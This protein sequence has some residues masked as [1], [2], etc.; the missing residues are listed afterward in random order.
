[1]FRRLFLDHPASVGESYLEHMGVASRFGFRMIGG[2]MGCAIH[3]V[4]PFLFKTRGSD[5][6]QALN[7]ELVAKRNAARAA[8]TQM[9]TVEYII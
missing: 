7:A 1:M 9:R 5:T 8:Q 4:L 6:V 2:G 3:A